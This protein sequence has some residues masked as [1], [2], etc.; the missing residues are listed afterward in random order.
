MRRPLTSTRVRCAPSPR[1]LAVASPYVDC[2]AFCW[3]VMPPAVELAEMF[4]RRCSALVPPVGQRL[5]GSSP[6]CVV[7]A[8]DAVH[9]IYRADTIA[10]SLGGEGWR[11]SLEITGL[12]P[13]HFQTRSA[14][15]AGQGIPRLIH[16]RPRDEA[17]RE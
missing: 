1:R 12:I 11:V 3:E 13:R 9:K 5:G 10:K 17:R 6:A 14:L 15:S 7:D 8:I 2:P 16:S 4:C